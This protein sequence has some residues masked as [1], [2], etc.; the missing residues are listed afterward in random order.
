[1]SL[2]VSTTCASTGTLYSHDHTDSAHKGLLSQCGGY[3]EEE[4][5]ESTTNV[6]GMV[7]HLVVYSVQ[8]SFF[9]AM[10]LSPCATVSL[11]RRLVQWTIIDIQEEDRRFHTLFNEVKAGKFE[12]IEVIDELKRASLLQVLVGSCNDKLMITSANHLCVSDR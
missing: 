7:G 2:T 8:V 1:M 4:E 5:E 9:V 12:C 10:Y 3:K 11:G 6:H